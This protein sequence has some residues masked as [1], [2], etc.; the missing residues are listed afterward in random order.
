MADTALTRQRPTLT[1]TDKAVAQRTV[2]GML[3]TVVDDVASLPNVALREMLPMLAQ[4]EKEVAAAL[5]RWLETA[6]NGNNRFTAHQY[7]QVLMQLRQARHETLRRL[8]K[9]PDWDRDLEQ[10]VL[11]GL[12]K[13][14]VRGGQ[15]AT[16]HVMNELAT[17][18]QLFGSQLQPIPI[19]EAMIIQRNQKTLVPRY[20]TSAKRYANGVWDDIRQ[21]LSLGMLQGETI[22]S[23]ANRL[24]RLGGPRGVVALRGVLGEPGAV[25]EL[26]SEGLFRRYRHWAE[27][28][29][30]T[31]M[32]NAYN[33]SADEAIKEAKQI[34]PGIKR[35][36]DASLDSRVCLICQGLHGEVVEVNQPFRDGSMHPPAHP[37]CRC[38]VV[39]WH[40]D[41]DEGHITPDSDLKTA[42]EKLAQEEALAKK[43]AR[44]EKRQ[45]ETK[46][47][48]Q[49]EIQEKQ[50]KENEAERQARLKLKEAQAKA[51][52]DAKARALE[53]A[54]AQAAAKAIAAEKRAAA[55]RAREAK[56]LAV[57]AQRKARAHPVGL[58]VGELGKATTMPEVWKRA[59]AEWHSARR[60]IERQL[61]S[62]GMTRRKY[63]TAQAVE[64]YKKPNT[65]GTHGWDGTIYLDDQ[66]AAG[67][68]EFSKLVQQ[69]P[70]LVAHA[71]EAVRLNF[72]RMRL[73][74]E[75]VN[76]HNRWAWASSESPEKAALGFQREQATKRAEKAR[77]AAIEHKKKLTP[78]QVAT[79]TKLHNVGDKYRTLVH[80]VIHGYMPG[81]KSA[82]RA[83]GAIVEEVGTETLARR[84][85]RK[86]FGLTVSGTYG[87]Y[88]DPIN[89]AISMELAISRGEAMRRIEQ[90]VLRARSKSKEVPLSGQEVVDDFLKE[91][92]LPG[93]AG[94]KVRAIIKRLGEEREK[95][96]RKRKERRR[97]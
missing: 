71:K 93:Q 55:E 50:A 77:D 53:Q 62:E 17:F 25:S 68:Q 85:M 37:R 88:I 18:N 65:H 66:V 86:E 33:V 72:E 79:L 92:N 45:Q 52:Q 82:Y 94:R 22:D 60:A 46:T 27:R 28:L 29:A 61:E 41:W 7:R 81:G 26:I 73:N 54:R 34:E 64:F 90:A 35:R 36:W 13:G 20:R 39:A 38:A 2:K 47:R 97:R 84:A 14:A 59:S 43:R 74:T 69:H 95:K 63:G 78:E 57:E 31:E 83:G 67:A 24:V 15:L 32:I 89:N 56:R 51:E 87:D 30:H 1:A 48:E 75:R 4:A 23:L 5:Q 19:V 44:E 10:S 8:R 40:E 12:Q 49:K 76:A 11:A 70:D 58:G 96:R 21:Q 91:L 16:R 80:E 9:T 42:E 3:R 6:P